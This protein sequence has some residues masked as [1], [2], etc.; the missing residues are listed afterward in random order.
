M[1]VSDGLVGSGDRLRNRGRESRP[2]EPRRGGGGGSGEC[3]PTRT[4]LVVILESGKLGSYFAVGGT[5][6]HREG[7]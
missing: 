4:V 6:A 3:G 1:V 2:D 7:K 5:E